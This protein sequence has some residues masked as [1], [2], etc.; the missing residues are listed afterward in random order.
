MP[1]LEYFVVSEAVS[2]DQ[3]TNNVSVFSISEK[4][5]VTIPASAPH[6]VATSSW[7]IAQDE[8]NRDFQ[9]TL[10]V[11]LDG[12]SVSQELD[13]FKINF[14]SERDRHRIFHHINGLKL[15]KAGELIFELLLDG[16]HVAYH[17]VTVQASNENG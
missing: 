7:N 10:R 4:L 15:K 14:T 3:Q 9:A 2:V 6:L 8:R 5:T 1:K 16:E 11:T 13:N 12:E 17:T